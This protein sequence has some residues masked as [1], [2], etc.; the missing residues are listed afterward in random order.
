MWFPDEHGRMNSFNSVVY[1]YTGASAYGGSGDITYE[2]DTMQANLKKKK[3]MRWDPKK[4]KF[5]KV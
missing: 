4:R 2:D 3:I 5:I 1:M